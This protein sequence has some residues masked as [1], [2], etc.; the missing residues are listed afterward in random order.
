VKYNIPILE[1]VIGKGGTIMP[2]N[3]NSD[4]DNVLIISGGNR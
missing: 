1:G 4:F 3:V 2:Y